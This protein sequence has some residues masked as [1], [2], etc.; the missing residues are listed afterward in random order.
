M[1]HSGRTVILDLVGPVLEGHRRLVNV[2]GPAVLPAPGRARIG[3]RVLLRPGAG[4]ATQ[5]GPGKV[6]SQLVRSSATGLSGSHA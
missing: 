1:F 4:N 5:Q 3:Q 6:P 2:S